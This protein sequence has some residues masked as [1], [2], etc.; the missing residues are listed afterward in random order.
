[1]HSHS[2]CNCEQRIACRLKPRRMTAYRIL[3]LQLERRARCSNG[4]T[5][6]GIDFTSIGRSVACSTPY[7]L[8]CSIECTLTSIREATAPIG[9][10][11]HSTN[12][13]EEVLMIFVCPHCN[14]NAFVLTTESAGR[15]VVTCLKCNVPLPFDTF[16]KARPQIRSDLEHSILEPIR[17]AAASA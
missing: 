8:T 3:C 5:S 17:H 13:E 16:T 2:V 11:R 1:M 10:A 15:T 12:S 6:L 4:N 7:R 14:L 9:R